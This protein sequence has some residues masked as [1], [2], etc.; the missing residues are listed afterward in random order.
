MIC[1]DEEGKRITYFY[2]WDIGRILVIN[3]DYQLTDAPTFHFCN[4]KTSEAYVVNSVLNQTKTE[5][6][7]SVPNILLQEV[8]DIFVYMYVYINDT[9]A[10]TLDYTKMPVR[11]RQMPSS[12]IYVENIDFTTLAQVE[13]KL[14]AINERIENLQSQINQLKTV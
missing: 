11:E 10:K 6:T 8:C 1:F 3:N 5:I 13:K 2:Q 14:V 7:V 4:S 9:S 12:Y